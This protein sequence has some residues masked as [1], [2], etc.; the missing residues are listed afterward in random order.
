MKLPT[1]SLISKNKR[2]LDDS[3]ALVV[4]L[5]SADSARSDLGLGKLLAP[6]DLTTYRSF[7]KD[8]GFK[9]RKFDSIYMPTSTGL[10]ILF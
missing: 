10:L 3:N 7:I 2:I 6:A 9:A 1:L 4:F 5:R 8:R